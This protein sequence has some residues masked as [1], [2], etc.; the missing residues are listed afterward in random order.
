MIK[1]YFVIRNSDKLAQFEREEMRRANELTYEQ[2]LR[3][4]ESLWLEAKTLGTVGTGDPLRGL[5]ADIEL[6]RTLNA[7]SRS[8]HV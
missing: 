4:F 7:L 2:A 6:A 1:F 8:R 3:L 5:D